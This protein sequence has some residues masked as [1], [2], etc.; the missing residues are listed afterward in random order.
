MNALAL[1]AV[2]VGPVLF[3]NLLF[4]LRRRTP[5]TLR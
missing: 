2:Y 5:A 3:A 1:I 4:T